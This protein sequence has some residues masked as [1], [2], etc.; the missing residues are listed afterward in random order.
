MFEAFKQDPKSKWI[1][2]IVISVLIILPSY[3]VLRQEEGSDSQGTRPQGLWCDDNGNTHIAGEDNGTAYDGKVKSVSVTFLHAGQVNSIT[4]DSVG[5]VVLAVP[6]QTIVTSP[7]HQIYQVQNSSF[8]QLE[9]GATFDLIV[10]PTTSKTTT[11]PV[12][13]YLVFY[14]H[15]S[16]NF[17]LETKAGNEIQISGA[18]VYELMEQVTDDIDGYNARYV[19]EGSPQLE[20]AAL[21]FE[22]LF[23]SYGLDAEVQRYWNGNILIMN[24]IAI[25]WG[26]DQ[27]TFI[28]VGG[29]MDVSTSTHQGAY[30]DTSE[31]VHTLLLAKAMASLE[32]RNTYFFGLWS[33]EEEG[34]WGSGEFV[35]NF[36]ENYP[37]ATIKA[38]FNLDMP[39]INYPGVDPATDEYYPLHGYVGGKRDGGVERAPELETIVNWTAHSFLNYP[40]ISALELGY[41]SF[42]SSD[43]VSFQRAGIP[44]VFFIGIIYEYSE[45]HS[46]D[47]TLATM[48][49]YMGGQEGLEAGFEVTAWMTLGSLLTLDNELSNSP[50]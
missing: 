7:D 50:L 18:D 31:T 24:V 32:T 22:S 41:S 44:T 16:F 21:F 35:N 9:E 39:G 2:V 17:T 48:R 45:L 4:L 10:S 47:D 46:R 15:G 23:D 37:G 6:A 8:L 43:H 12:A 5:S 28:G 19:S 29:H 26:Q 20:R 27:S 34:I 13:I 3:L 11:L 14:G 1:G 30:D 40:N 36:E 38:Y 33:A 25:K 49:D 42:G